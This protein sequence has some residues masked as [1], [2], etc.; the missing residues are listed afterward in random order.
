MDWLEVAV[1]AVYAATEAVADIFVQLG[2]GGTAIED[3]RELNFHIKSGLWDC[4]DLKEAADTGVAIVK[5]YWPEDGRIKDRLSVLDKR[6]ALVGER[7]PGAIAGK[8]SFCRVKEEDWENSWKQ[9]FH[10]VRIGQRIVI[11]PSWE[12]YAAKDGDI[13]IHIDPGMAFG[14]GTHHSTCLCA[15]KLE[16]IIRPG[17]TVFDAGTGSGIL[18]LLCA[19]LGAERITAVDSDPVAVAVARENVRLNALT[20]KINVLEGDLL[21]PAKGRADVIAANITADVIK[22]LLPA[23]AR[24]LK[25]SGVF[26]AGGILSGRADEI[27]AAAGAAALAA[28]EVVER[29][30]WALLAMRKK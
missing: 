19:R 3:P 25:P 18:S 5:A 23:A 30:G 21:A 14:T 6:L 8:I 28:D 15:E 27:I 11:K 1:P 7:V 4:T 29:E 12:G 9:Y 2:A 17:Q 13:I 20:D 22:R 26:L 16:Q 10:P 24:K